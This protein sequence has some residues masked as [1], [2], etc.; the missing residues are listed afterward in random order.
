MK[1]YTLVGTR[2]RLEPCISSLVTKMY[3]TKY[4]E[5]KLLSQE[6]KDDG[7]WFQVNEGVNKGWVRFDFVKRI[8]DEN[9]Q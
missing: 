4:L 7:L 2:I 5:L 1:L 8:Y 6:K 9:L 3:V